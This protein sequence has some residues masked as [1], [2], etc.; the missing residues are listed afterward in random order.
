M[1]ADTQT[2][3]DRQGAAS[4]TLLE[5]IAHSY[6]H[7]VQRDYLVASG[8]S[9]AVGLGA[10]LLSGETD[11]VAATNAS[12]WPM[13][14]T[15]IAT[16]WALTHRR[17][18]A[19]PSVRGTTTSVLEQNLTN[20]PIIIVYGALAYLTQLSATEFGMSAAVAFVGTNVASTIITRYPHHAVYERYQAH[21][22][23]RNTAL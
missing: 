18:R 10:L 21:K 9:I 17:T 4:P 3:Q 2:T 16:Q 22:Q 7:P 11:P 1:T 19:A 12:F 5:R 14:G 20:L 6:T 8:V 15:F 23:R 13:Q